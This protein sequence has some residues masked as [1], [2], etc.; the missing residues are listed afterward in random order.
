M[1]AII[2]LIYMMKWNNISFSHKNFYCKLN[3]INKQTDQQEVLKHKKQ[4][5]QLLKTIKT[6][7]LMQIQGQV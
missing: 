3:L 1:A 5:E 2:I 4:A 7:N 6:K